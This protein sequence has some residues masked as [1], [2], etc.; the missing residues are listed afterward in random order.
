[1]SPILRPLWI[2][3]ALALS[4]AAFA[5]DE[6]D[7]ERRVLKARQVDTS[8]NI[9]EEFAK[10]AEAKRLEAISRLKE[11]LGKG[12]EGDQ[13][14]EMM[15]RLA[16]LYFQQGRF[17]YLKEMAA[18]DVEFDKCFNTEGCN[19]DKL[20][21]NNAGSREWQEKSIKLYENIIANYPR[22]AKADQ[23]T[24]FLGSALLDVG[25]KDDAVEA[26]KK[27]V[28]LYSEST[29]VPDSYVLIGEYYFEA[30]N[31][32]AAL[33]AYLKATQYTASEKYPFAM[34]K[35]AW[36]YY[37]VGDYTASIDTMKAVVSFSQGL[38]AD[39]KKGVNLEDEALKDLVRFFADA[40]AMN[41]AYEYFTKLGK[42]DLI[43]SMLSRL[44]ATYF[45]Q[46]KFD[47]SIETFRRL[48]LEDPNGVKCPEYQG[49]IISAYRKMGAKDRTLEEIQRLLRDYGKQSAWARA[50]ASNP[51]VVSD[52][53]RKVEENLRRAAI[54]YHNDAKQLE[55]GR[56]KDAATTYDLARQAYASY[57]VEF[58]TDEH[59]YDVRYAYG[60]LLYHLKDY[61]GAFEQYMKVVDTNPTGKY[62][63][64]CAESAVFAAEEQVKLE[65]GANAG[66]KVTVT[67]KDK[68][69]PQS[70]TEWEQRFVDACKRYAELYPGDPK[71]RG[72]IYKSGYMLYNKYRFEEA[73]AQF[74]SVIAMEPASKDAETAAELI[75]D[76]FVVREDWKNLKENAKFFYDQPSLGSASFKKETYNVYERASFKLI[77]TEFD[78]DKDKG[79]AADA[80]VAFYTE[81]PT[82]ETAAQALNNASIYYYDES[83]VADE[84]KVRHILI[85]DEKFGT[86]TKYYYDQVAALGDDYERIADFDRCAFYYEKLYALW[87]DELK[88]W[89]GKPDDES[90]VSN[91]AGDA[92]YS[93][94][95]FRTAMGDWVGGVANY[96]QFMASFPADAR[97]NDIRLRVAKIYEEHAKWEEAG[98]IYQAYYTKPPAEA[99]ADNVYGAR[100]HHGRALTSAGQKPKA[101]KLYQ[102][103]VDLWKKSGKPPGPPT[104]FVAEMMYVLAQPQIDKYLA[105]KIKGTG[106]PAK[107]KAEQKAEDKALT[108]SLGAKSKSLLQVQGTFTD[109]V[110]TGAGEWGLAGL[111]A[112]GKAYENMADSLTNGDVPS[113]LTE[114]QVEFYK[115]NIADKAYVQV[116][117]AVE[118]YK[119][120]LDKSFELTLYNENT[121]YATRQ[122]GVLRPD[123]FPGL[124]EELLEPRYTSTKVRVYPAEQAL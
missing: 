3:A 45:E 29:Y 25:R 108:D 123:E 19:T 8:A 10:A 113:Y 38:A 103:T 95:V 72:V 59:A 57:L 85:D 88:K 56:H 89:K 105:L 40:G 7:E 42:K 102:E 115:L 39:Q 117:K 73:A 101:D 16:D 106:K 121:A 98:A 15:L 107:S 100:L 24:F 71:V 81:F 104:E 63:K 74:R 83:R 92:L 53:M 44:A 122:L 4:S 75:L 14:A 94:A 62:S 34:Y 35:L 124:H 119:T 91:K 68:R 120:A 12:V 55:K 21:A 67:A 58:E 66:T 23:A 90:R 96:D 116:E 84:M 13:K 60:E 47:Q 87:P 27:L 33:R 110:Q 52:A 5:A 26:F 118:A 36:C 65:G 50:N 79:K 1:M 2:A 93:A 28:K 17:L 111:V 80:F 49:E 109:I 30:N 11:L 41:D 54:T 112:L 77:E 6:P 76:S 70:L 99:S 18:F 69:E 31:A 78:K 114:D 64:F 20:V 37:N 82:A 48:I 46:G 43:Q 32:Y 61:K 9:S 97:V 51:L 86:K 22:Y